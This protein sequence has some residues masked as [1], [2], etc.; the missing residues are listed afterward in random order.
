M[1]KAKKR[2]FRRPVKNGYKCGLPQLQNSLKLVKE[3][4]YTAASLGIQS[5]YKFRKFFIIN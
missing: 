4:T 2:L 5:K 1:V 3:N